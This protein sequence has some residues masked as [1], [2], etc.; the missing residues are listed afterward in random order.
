MRSGQI[1][2]ASMLVASSL[3]PLP[4][5]KLIKHG[6]GGRRESRGGRG[7]ERRRDAK[8]RRH[9][10]ALET[11]LF[12]LAHAAPALAVAARTLAALAV[13]ALTPR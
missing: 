13:L 8:H 10:C 5:L 4:R 12:T 11:L 1:P 2:A 9:D 3:V 7:E 6:G